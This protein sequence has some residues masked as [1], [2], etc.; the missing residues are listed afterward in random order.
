MHV[1][2]GSEEHVPIEELESCVTML[3][4]VISQRA[5]R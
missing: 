1:A 2:H 3:R 4:E 5:S